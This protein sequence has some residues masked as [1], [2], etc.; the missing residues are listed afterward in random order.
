MQLVAGVGDRVVEVAFVVGSG[1]GSLVFSRCK[2][3]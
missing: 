1:V 3:R 2:G